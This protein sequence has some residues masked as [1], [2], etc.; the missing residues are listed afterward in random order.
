M[1]FPSLER[2]LDKVRDLYWAKGYNDVRSEYRLVLD[3]TAGLVDLAIT[4]KEGRQTL[5][6]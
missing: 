6:A 3:R 2:S 1:T 4:I 5:I